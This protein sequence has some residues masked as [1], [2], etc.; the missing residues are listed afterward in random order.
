M[1]SQKKR[2]LFFLLFLSTNIFYLNAQV[3]KF[4]PNP[5]NGKGVRAGFSIWNNQ[6]FMGYTKRSDSNCIAFFDG[7]ILKTL[8][9]PKD[10]SYISIIGSY[11]KDFSAVYNDKIYF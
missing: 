3:L 6:L 7:K 9:T 8:T 5:D 11:M 2:S 1:I 10:L 4:I